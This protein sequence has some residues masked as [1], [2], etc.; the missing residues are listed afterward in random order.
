MRT[1]RLAPLLLPLLV[2]ACAREPRPVRIGIALAEAGQTAG[3]IAIADANADPRT[4][5][6]GLRFEAVVYTQAG[7]IDPFTAVAL[8]DSLVDDPRVLGVV[9]HSNSAAS[10]AAAQI[11]NRHRLPQLAP[12]TTAPLYGDAGPYSF[13]MVPDD[14]H[15]G[16]YLGSVIAAHPA[17]RR[18]AVVYV[19]D[20]YGRALWTALEAA[21]RAPS[22]E[23]VSQAPI[24]EGWDS[25]SMRLAAETVAGSRPDVVVWLA[26]APELSDFRG[27]F[28]RLSPSVPFLAGDGV[29]SATL[30][31]RGNEPYRGVTFVRFVDPL[32]GDTAL[33]DFRARYRAAARREATAD[34]VLAYDAARLLAE[35]VLSGA[36][37][38]DDVHRYLLSLDGRARTYRGIAGT[39]S[40]DARRAA[41]RD[42]LLATIGPDGAVAPSAPGR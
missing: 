16:T 40:F 25:L 23:V 34:A 39:V 35:A 33:Q 21:L 27:T 37:T 31:E 30:F 14:T 3:R 22:V 29:D 17:W 7:T 20:D 4:A 24:L 5:R 2:A 8:A 18:V 11:Y 28:D 1:I 38:R 42:Y 36:R 13:R 19:N 41:R 6:S 15:Q 26:R 10:M 12:T 32:H 9:G